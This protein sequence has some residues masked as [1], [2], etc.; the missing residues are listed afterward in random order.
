MRGASLKLRVAYDL[1]MSA[2]AFDR[3]AGLTLHLV[4]ARGEIVIVDDRGVRTGRLRCDG[5]L[6][7]TD[8]E[9]RE[10]S[11]ATPLRVALFGER[12]LRG[13]DVDDV[14]ISSRPGRHVAA[15]A[16]APLASFS[17]TVFPWRSA[18]AEIVANGSTAKRVAR[19]DAAGLG[20][21]V[22]FESDTTAAQRRIALWLYLGACL[23]RL[24]PP[25][26]AR[27]VIP[28]AL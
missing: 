8:F 4:Q 26:Y 25:S 10:D 11:S 22:G 12:R 1:G 14:R 27:Y 6:S 23:S 17:Y 5:A 3:L 7:L 18:V 19:V 16:S 9:G 28:R 21:R 20:V 13:P 2:I 24:P 15:R